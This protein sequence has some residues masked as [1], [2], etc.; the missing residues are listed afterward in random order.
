MFTVCYSTV[1]LVLTCLLCKTRTIHVGKF[2][3]SPN[4]VKY[5]SIF[6]FLLAL[7]T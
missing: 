6:T 7:D 1:M 2:T 3:A 4:F 5:C